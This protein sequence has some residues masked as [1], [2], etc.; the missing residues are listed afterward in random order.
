MSKIKLPEGGS[1]ARVWSSYTLANALLVEHGLR[2]VKCPWVI[3]LTNDHRTAGVCM[4]GRHII[5][6]SA[7]LASIWSEENTRDTILH[8]IAHALTGEGHTP[9][10]RACCRKIGARPSRCWGGNGEAVIPEKWKG[11]CPSGH[12]L[13]RARE[14]KKMRRMSCDK[15]SRRWNPAYIY[16]WTETS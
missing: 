1:P 16:A 4:H 10:W 5:E 7:P 8:E 2:D 9:E 12:V 3:K 15:C 13:Y 14:T 11:T 6:L